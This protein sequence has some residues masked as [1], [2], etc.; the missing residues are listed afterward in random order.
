MEIIKD[1]LIN[2]K[3]DAM[4]MQYDDVIMVRTHNSVTDTYPP[5]RGQPTFFF[6]FYGSCTNSTPFGPKTAFCPFFLMTC[7]PEGVWPPHFHAKFHLI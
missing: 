2:M 1:D 3:Y 5:K 7:P 6:L 4:M